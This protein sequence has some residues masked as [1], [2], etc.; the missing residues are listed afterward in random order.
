M[1][2]WNFVKVGTSPLSVLD[3]HSVW[4]EALGRPHPQATL[5][6]LNTAVADILTKWR[7]MVFILRGQGIPGLNVAQCLNCPPTGGVTRE[8]RGRFTHACMQYRAC[9]WCWGRKIAR[10]PYAAV[11]GALPRLGIQPFRPTDPATWTAPYL[12]CTVASS[13]PGFKSAAGA[14]VSAAERLAADGRRLRRLKSVGFVQQAVVL[15][16]ADGFRVRC[17]YA[18]FWPAAEPFP[19]EPKRTAVR[20]GVF[21]KIATAMAVRS[22]VAYGRQTLDGDGRRLAEL[23]R[24]RES[25]RLFRTGGA[26]YAVPADPRVDPGEYPED[27]P[28]GSAAT[29]PSAESF[30]L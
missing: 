1:Y 24:F 21:S 29:E 5:A 20:L 17:G 6:G 2:K 14:Y 12:L 19:A 25:G 27:D 9:P 23:L 3:R 4:A 8:V 22:L 18:T 13:E 11:W 16:E 26:C 7:R 30:S 15:P 10:R 28:S